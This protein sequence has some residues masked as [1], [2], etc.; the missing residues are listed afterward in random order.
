MTNPKL[1]LTFM[2]GDVAVSIQEITSEYILKESISETFQL[3]SALKSSSRQMSLSLK[4]NTPAIEH[5]IATESDIKAELYDGSTAV[6][7]GYLSTNYS[8][9]VN[10]AGES[11][12]SLTIE[13]VGTRLLGKAFIKNGSHLFK[14]TASAAI[15]V[16]AE[17]AGVTL[18]SNI[19]TIDT[20]IVKVV[21]EGEKCKDILSTMLYEVG[22][23]YY[24]END[25]K[26]N[27]FSFLNLGKSED[28]TLDG[29]KLI[30]KSGSGITL[31]KTIRQYNSSKIRYTELG[32]ASHYLVYRNTTDKDDSH[33]YCNL[34]LQGGEAF[35]GAEI[36]TPDKSVTRTD[37]KIE[38]VN[39]LSETEIIG[40][41]T[42]V[43]IENVEALIEKYSPI[44]ASIKGVGGPY[45]TVYAENPALTKRSITRM[46]AYATVTYE[47]SENIVL[48]GE[49]TTSS[50]NT[51]EEELT[52]VHDEATAKKHAALVSEYY[53][54][55]GGSYTFFSREDVGVGKLVR[56]KDDIHTGLN[57]LLLVYAKI[58]NDSNSIIEYR[59][60]G[61]SE[62]NLDKSILAEKHVVSP[63]K[64][65]GAQGEAGKAQTFYYQWS[66]SEE[67]FTPQDARFW[68]KGTGFIHFGSSMIG[69]LPYKSGWITD[70]TK[71]AEGKT[72]EYPYL[73]CKLS[74]DSEP[75]LFSGY[76]G[77]T[78]TTVTI[79]RR[80]AEKP[81]LPTETVVYNFEEFT[82]TGLGDWSL[83][84]PEGEE[85]VWS[86]SAT[87][88]SA[89][90]VSDKIEPSEWSFPVVLVENGKGGL[91]IATSADSWLFAADEDGIVKA[92]DYAA[93]EVEVYVTRGGKSVEF[94][95]L[96]EQTGITNI[97]VS[98]TK[99]VGSTDTVMVKDSASLKL[100]IT[101]E[102]ETYMKV[103]SLSKA[104]TGVAGAGEFREYCLST[105][106][107]E[108]PTTGWST[109][110]PNM[111]DTSHY[112]W[113][114][115]KTVESGQDPDEVDW[116][117]PVVTSVGIL[118]TDSKVTLNS[119]GSK[120]AVGEAEILL[121]APNVISP[122]TITATEMHADAIGG[123][124]FIVNNGGAIKSENWDSSGGTE[125]FKM[126][127]GG[128]IDAQDIT[129][130]K[131]AIVKGTIQNDVFRTV[132]DAV[133]GETITNPSWP[134]GTHWSGAE[135]IEV[136]SS[137]T[138][139]ENVVLVVN[140]KS[141]TAGRLRRSGDTYW[142]VGYYQTVEIINP[143]TKLPTF[144]KE[145]VS[146]AYFY[147][148]KYYADVVTVTLSDGTVVFDS[149]NYLNHVQ[150]SGTGK[151]TTIVGMTS[152]SGNTFTGVD[153]NGKTIEVTPTSITVTDVGTI[154][155]G[156]WYNQS[157]WPTY[158]LTLLS[159][160]LGAYVSN[161]YPEKDKK[162]YIGGL[163]EGQKFEAIYADNIY[164]VG[165]I[166]ISTN[167]T[168]PALYYGG[169]WERIKGQF[170]L[171]SDDSTYTLGAT[172]GEAEHAL[173][174]AQMPN[175]RHIV[176]TKRIHD[177]ADGY[178]DVY[179]SSMGTVEYPLAR[180]NGSAYYDLDYTTYAGS[181]G[182]SDD[183]GWPHNNMPPYLVVYIWKRL[184]D[185]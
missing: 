40:S 130:G 133:S 73:W 62:F 168:S 17:K 3:F 35:D 176:G 74:E 88:V 38:A 109:A 41:R 167:S 67:V 64:D 16:I 1:I 5:I 70:A 93:F 50:D 165:S 55:S 39:A 116:S 48:S 75:F 96:V 20:E 164:P 108:A 29:T 153:A 139:S 162:C 11:N 110:A 144:K 60:V 100:S 129:L 97:I 180:Y 174:Y 33:P 132:K 92:E 65:M 28:A 154:L 85:K 58:T 56:V 169:N 95:L 138:G 71:V 91:V 30:V 42:I 32:T 119:D 77:G 124:E 99:V 182:R 113:M 18:S 104:R 4:R 24:F 171:G 36:Y 158:S 7:T 26:M 2:G 184:P 31:N 106:R 170:L 6:F 121:D 156:E 78:A 185:D 172:G 131:D 142:T 72:D 127:S 12:L 163:A 175:H 51:I 118:V 52:Y 49:D 151:T 166:Y 149:A 80:S 22:Y 148:E 57:V 123:K 112:L 115:R 79:Y 178:A 15:E 141:Y 84:T 34:V 183:T 37:V 111:G 159:E 155:K 68:I 90:G 63:S 19:P 86:S 107:T 59:A 137:Y 160:N 10:H 150:W 181:Y 13:D 25:G 122:G 128:H 45:L 117:T 102:G 135:S 177:S 126:T 66:K 173:T 69:S 146:Y 21:S 81:S 54:Y 43:A 53:R 9:S 147:G 125:G 83:T 143:T 103:V 94:S 87:A 157:T 114:R 152:T 23:V 179:K 134:G 61:Y 27:L 82:A 161:L 89:D 47:K 76:T 14:C 101:V 120:L 140:G 46:D 8:W 145:W 105:S 98:G 136:L 44:T